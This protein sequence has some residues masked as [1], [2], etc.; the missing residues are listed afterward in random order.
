MQIGHGNFA[1][2]LVAT[3]TLVLSPFAMAQTAAMGP[4]VT[5]NP[6]QFPLP[7][8]GTTSVVGTVSAAQS[9]NWKV[10][11]V[12]T[13]EKGRHAYQWAQ[14][15]GG[16]VESPVVPAGKRLVVDQIAL[17]VFVNLGATP[18][19]VLVNIQ[20]N[21]ATVTDP[22]FVLPL[23]LAPGTTKYATLF[24]PLSAYVDA[25]K[26]IT[27]GFGVALVGQTSRIAVTGH[28]LDCTIATCDALAP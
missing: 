10:T 5:L 21:T 26:K 8:S 11:S 20:G 27:I 18:T 19:F 14:E 4:V 1:L 15:F 17:S 6:T 25:G 12:D 3:G 16:S 22:G 9:G 24:S 2:V 28:M 13:D 7:V 23:L